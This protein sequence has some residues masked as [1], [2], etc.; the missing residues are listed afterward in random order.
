MTREEERAPSVLCADDYAMSSAI[1]DAIDEL[2][3]LGHISATS[4]IV[5]GPEWPAHGARLS[6]LKD[7]I[8]IGLHLNFTWGAPL[9]QVPTLTHRGSLPC[10]R[11]LVKKSLLS[12]IDREE[13]AA[14]VARQVQAFKEGVGRPPDFVDGHEHAHALPGVRHGVLAG[15]RQTI[16]S[17]ELVVRDP[18]DTPI[19]IWKRHV[20]VPKALGIGMLASGFRKLCQRAGYLTNSGFSG[21]SNFQP[22]S[23]FVDELPRFFTNSGSRHLVMCHPGKPDTASSGDPILM[24]RAKEYSVLREA[25]WLKDRIWRPARVGSQLWET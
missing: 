1:C 23:A 10:I 17:D 22:T 18:F 9:G 11:D 14:E 16:R 19:A 8:A 6:R 3:A 21:I 7:T 2:A 20:A 24:R 12:K 5:T 25:T 13:I 15:L 4:A